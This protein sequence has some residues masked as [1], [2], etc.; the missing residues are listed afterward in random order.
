MSA[1]TLTL[2]GGK[3][4]DISE[5]FVADA[6]RQADTST[7]DAD[8]M[9]TEEQAEEGL[10]EPSPSKTPQAGETTE[11]GANVS[12]ETQTEPTSEEQADPDPSTEEQATDDGTDGMVVENTRRLDNLEEAVGEIRNG[13]SEVLN[14]VKGQANEEQMDEED[15]DDED[16]DMDEED[17]AGDMRDDAAEIADKL[18]VSTGDV[19]DALNDRFGDDEQQAADDADGD[20]EGESVAQ[21]Q[22]PTPAT[23]GTGQGT[24]ANTPTTDT[25]AGIEPAPGAP[26]AAYDLGPNDPNDLEKVDQ[27]AGRGESWAND[28]L[29][30]QAAQAELGGV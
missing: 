25:D 27:A 14:A 8:S 24:P 17:M 5:S 1:P 29:I 9:E 20:G 12:E 26:E 19:L 30:R 2:S 18:G 4:V 15:H 22:T 10:G 21:A 7:P 28:E 13:M 6:I 3:E 16:E 23:P 11:E